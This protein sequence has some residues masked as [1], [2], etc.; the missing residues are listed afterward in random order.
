MKLKIWHD[1]KCDTIEFTPDYN[2][3]LW[4]SLGIEVDGL[5]EKEREIEIQRRFDEQFNRPE[6]NNWHKM[7]R[8]RGYTKA[9][10]DEGEDADYDVDELLIEDVADS[11]IFYQDELARDERY[12]YEDLCDRIRSAMKPDYAEMVIAIY[13]DGIPCKEYARSIGEDPNTV[14]HRLQRAKKICKEIFVKTSF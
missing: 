5:S 9:R 11:R 10:P 2:D 14:N 6:Y 4:V 12:T 13:L 8:H 7:D 1:N 3:K